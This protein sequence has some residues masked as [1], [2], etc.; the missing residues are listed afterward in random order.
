MLGNALIGLR[1]GLEAA[2]VVSILVA[3]LVQTDR[4]AELPKVWLG[5]GIAVAVSVGVTLALALTQQALTFEA[6]EALGGS[7]SIIAVGFVT[8]MIFWMRATRAR[9][10]GRP[11]RQA[12][13][14]DPDRAG[15][16]RRHGRARR[17]SRGP[18]D[19]GVLLHRRPGA[20]AR[21]PSR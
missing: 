13:R 11:A 6:Q 10:S 1:E 15:R 18:G 19:R 20:R 14:R 9:I 21:P 5:V 8:W 2:L 7:L 4:R 17:R 16:R 3:F 12:G